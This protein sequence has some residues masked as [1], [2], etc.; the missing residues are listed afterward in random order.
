MKLCPACGKYWE[1]DLTRCQN[2]GESLPS[3]EASSKDA[4]EG[5]FEEDEVYYEV[6]EFD[7]DADDN[8]TSTIACPF[9]DVE[10]LYSYS[11][12]RYIEDGCYSNDIQYLTCPSCGKH[13]SIDHEAEEVKVMWKAEVRNL[14]ACKNGESPHEWMWGGWCLHCNAVN[15]K[16]RAE[17]EKKQAVERAKRSEEAKKFR[18]RFDAGQMQDTC[19]AA[20][21]TFLPPNF[22][23]PKSIS[24]IRNMDRSIKEDSGCNSEIIN[25]S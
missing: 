20:T 22:F 13:F 8:M 12:P 2:C 25:P 3:N 4:D 10:S 21:V 14:L 17:A 9:C 19:S 18:Q 1:N 15:K 16:M 23:D 7:V 6:D 24:A 5:V 11:E